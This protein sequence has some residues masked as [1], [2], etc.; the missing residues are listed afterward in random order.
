MRVIH[1]ADARNAE[2]FNWKSSRSGFAAAAYLKNGG[3]NSK[4]EAPMSRGS[5]SLAHAPLFASLDAR[6]VRALDAR[7]LW[8]TVGAGEWVID[9]KSDGQDVFFVSSG[10]ARVVI[11][12]ASRSIILRDIHDGEF[13]GEL[14][15]ID[16]QPR[17]AGILAVTD[18]VV[19]RMSAALFRDTIHAHPSVCDKVLATLAAAIRA[20]NNRADEHANL[21]IRQRLC[22]ELLRLSRNA[23]EGRIVVSPPPTHA[24][25]AA[26]ISTH[27]EAVTKLLNAL[28]R[29]GLISRK[30]GAITLTNVES[31]RHIIARQR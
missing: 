1:P 13:F 30:R 16:G 18:T 8:R 29:E 28:E 10:H 25:L 21:D 5:G 7:C 3:D 31:L 20:L 23:A 12:P 6:D 19:A 2:W 4:G 24:E 17:S 26:R 15:A 14:S 27:R 11:G 22:A 9:D